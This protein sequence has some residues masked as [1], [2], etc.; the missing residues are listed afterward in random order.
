MKQYEVMISING[1]AIAVVEAN[2]LDDAKEKAK[3]WDFS[4]EGELNEWGYEEVLD[5]TLI[6]ND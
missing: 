6:N 5:V 2:S 1:N 4:E 3:N